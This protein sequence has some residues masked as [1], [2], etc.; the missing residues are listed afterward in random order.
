MTQPRRRI[1]V[2][3]P[4][5]SGGDLVRALGAEGVDCS[6]YWQKDPFV[7][8]D[9]FDTTLPESTL[10]ALVDEGA[11]DA[12][13][14]GSEIAVSAAEVLADRLG[15]ATN[16]PALTFHRR[17]K[18]GMLA[19]LSA[20][21]IQVPQNR[22]VHHV[23][24][25]KGLS[26]HFDLPVMVKPAGSAGSDSCLIADSWPEVREHVAFVLDRPSI[27]GLP[28]DSVAVQEYVDGAQFFV[29]TVSQG[30]EHLVTDVYSCRFEIVSG[31]PQLKCGRSFDLDDE[32]VSDIVQYVLLALDAL[33][34][35]NGA[36]HTEVR[37]GAGGPR[38]IEFNGRL[39]GP[40]QPVEFFV[41]AQGTAKRPPTL[42]R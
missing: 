35:R 42:Q 23:S 26:G 41:A 14:A 22:T 1:L 17:D 25:V 31:S 6:T 7:R 24:E 27:M 19:A 29:N 32:R 16:E 13:V 20:A 15:T 18:N 9:P 40:I 10:V 5:S 11:F 28:I 33:G 38:L 39:M 2:L 21:G 12:I 37:R 34:V 8:A 30:G 3:D 4:E 36:G